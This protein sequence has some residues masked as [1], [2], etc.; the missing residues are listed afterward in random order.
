MLDDLKATLTALPS[1][2]VAQVANTLTELLRTRAEEANANDLEA[3]EFL[4]ELGHF[5]AGKALSMGLSEQLDIPQSPTSEQLRLSLLQL[6]DD[7]DFRPDVERAIEETPA[8]FLPAIEPVLLGSLVVFVLSIK[9]RFKVKV[10]D[11]KKTI[12]FQAEKTATPLS[13][14]KKVFTYL[15]NPAG[16]GPGASKK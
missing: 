12:E 7:P 14:L 9:W 4:S 8:T 13:L 16:I 1:A 2:K 5:D 10:K 11:G 15:L 3:M 6:A